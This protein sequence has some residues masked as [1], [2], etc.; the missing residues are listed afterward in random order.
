MGPIENYSDKNFFLFLVENRR[1]NRLTKALKV[2]IYI[3]DQLLDR[4]LFYPDIA[5]NLPLNLH[6]K[7]SEGFTAPDSTHT[8]NKEGFWS[9]LK[10]FFRKENGVQSLNI[11]SLIDDIVFKK[12][13]MIKSTR[14]NF[15]IFLYISLNTLLKTKI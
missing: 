12:R 5:S 1:V 10:R 11:Y 4:Y 3:G 7:N 6:L 9:H 15:H 2:I 8:N 13:Y 14:K